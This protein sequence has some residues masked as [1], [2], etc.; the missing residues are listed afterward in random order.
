[1]VRGVVRMTVGGRPLELTAGEVVEQMRGQDPESV[2]E[3]FV[4]VAGSVPP[5]SSS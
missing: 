3:H 1:M 4:E 2:R 5:T